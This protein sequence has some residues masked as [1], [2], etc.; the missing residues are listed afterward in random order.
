[1]KTTT[2]W[3]PTRGGPTPSPQVCPGFPVAARR[4]H[5]CRCSHTPGLQHPLGEG[6]WGPA[7]PAGTLPSPLSAPSRSHLPEDHPGGRAQG[8]GGGWEQLL[9]HAVHRGASGSRA[10]GT[11]PLLRR[12]ARD[13][14]G[15]AGGEDPWPPSP[16]EQIS[17]QEVLWEERVSPSRGAKKPQLALQPCSRVLSWHGLR[18]QH[19]LTARRLPGERGCAEGLRSSRPRGCPTPQPPRPPGSAQHRAPFLPTRWVLS[20]GAAGSPG[21][22]PA[23]SAAQGGWERVDVF[24]K[25]Q[26]VTE[27]GGFSLQQHPPV[28][29]ER[30]SAS[31][32]LLRGGG[33][34][35]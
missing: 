25:K 32:S 4:W 29:E 6:S 21:I 35:R 33:S 3:W 10:P 1:M 22:L 11:L 15:H 16:E 2:G 8:A 34:F 7:A 18:S 19:R 5:R 20:L 24:I 9:G 12:P 27:P 14:A 28:Q 23:R 13:P 26:T 31:C 30:G 17:L